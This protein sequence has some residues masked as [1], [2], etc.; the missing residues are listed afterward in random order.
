MACK[1]ILVLGIPDTYNN[2]HRL[3]FLLHEVLFSKTV[4]GNFKVRTQIS[5]L[6]SFF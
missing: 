1:D 3:F 2:L 5:A 4:H 6:I